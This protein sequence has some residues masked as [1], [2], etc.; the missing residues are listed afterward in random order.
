MAFVKRFGRI[1]QSQVDSLIAQMLFQRAND[2]RV[3]RRQNLIGQ[4]DDSDM[5]TAPNEILGH[6]DADESGSDDQRVSTASRD[7]SVQDIGIGE[8][9]QSEHVRTVDSG[10]RRPEGRRSRG[11]DQLVIRFIVR[12]ARHQIRHG[13]G[14]SCRD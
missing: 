7:P 12:L 8:I 6:F 14:S 5:Q 1:I 3:P 11:N 2:F 4:F 9:A 10:N 13:D